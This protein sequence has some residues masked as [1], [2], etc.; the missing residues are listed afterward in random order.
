MPFLCFHYN[1]FRF[2]ANLLEAGFLASSLIG[3]RFTFSLCCSKLLKW[4]AF[5]IIHLMAC[6]WNL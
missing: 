5:E 6:A 3:H 1:R 2:Q 4:E